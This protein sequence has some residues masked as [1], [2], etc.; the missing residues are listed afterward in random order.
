MFHSPKRKY[1]YDMNNSEK[2]NTNKINDQIE[3]NDSE[4]NKDME[5][6]TKLE[7]L[8]FQNQIYNLN[9]GYLLE[10][11]TIF[12]E[13]YSKAIES[14]ENI[15]YYKGIFSYDGL[16]KLCKSFK[17]YDSIKE[18]F[19]SFCI[20]FQ[21]KKAYLQMNE[22]KSFDL[23]FLVYSFTG[24]EEEV[25]FPLEAHKLSLEK[26]DI[27]DDIKNSNCK[28]DEKEKEINIKIEN[29]EKSLRQENYELK[30]E[31]YYLKNDISRYVKTIENNKKEIKCLREQIKNLKNLIEIKFNNIS[32]KIT[33]SSNQKTSNSNIESKNN[34][35]NEIHIEKNITEGNLKSQKISKNLKND[36]VIDNKNTIVKE[37][38]KKNN[39]IEN[40]Q[41]KL[42]KNQEKIKNNKREIYKQ[43]KE[44]TAKKL[45]N[46]KEKSS[47]S[48]FLKKQKINTNKKNQMLNKSYTNTGILAIKKNKIDDI[49]ENEKDMENDVNENEIEENN[50]QAYIS[51]DGNK[52]NEEENNKYKNFSDKEENV[53]DG[54]LSKKIKTNEVDRNYMI[55]QWT[56]DFNLNVKKLLEDNDIKLKYTEKLNYMNRHILTK[57]EE[58][59]IIENQIL[60]EYPNIKDIKYNLIYR[61]SEHGDLAKTFHQKCNVPNNLILI[62]SKDGIKF[63]G[64]TQEDWEGID[65]FKKDKHAF[66]FSLNKNKIYKVDEDKAAIYCNDNIGPCFGEKFFEIF[67]NF[68]TK[69][70]IC[71]N[72]DKCGYIGLDD[73]YEI[74]NGIQE[75]SVEE[76]EIYQITLNY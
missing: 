76:I 74:T 34:E 37:N 75:F 46:N 45:N 11:N 41:N 30:N 28:W 47:F 54:I 5:N 21:N 57:I 70:G 2:Q 1:N 20:I 12:F 59:Q 65:I 9:F 67:D 35:N 26:N 27:K 61:S 22:N 19:S 33:N 66:C 6:I 42:N 73:D 63:G 15:Y 68:L 62:K 14:L 7:T 39:K 52:N 50:N 49:D 58:L 38:Q 60:T 4:K 17:M 29:I 71:F 16:M 53:E 44:E 25:I 69:G 3:K 48:E 55:D 51:E 64:Y 8:E 56:E 24:K 31:I 43:M 13:L 10:N 23:I 32:E 72:K 40:K 36:K 18:L